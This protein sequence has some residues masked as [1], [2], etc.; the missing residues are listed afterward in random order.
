MTN[1]GLTRILK[2]KSDEKTTVNGTEQP[3]IQQAETKRTVKALECGMLLLS[4]SPAVK[5]AAPLPA[6][7]GRQSGTV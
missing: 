4:G 2:G 3:P 7:S 1:R 5:A 6:L